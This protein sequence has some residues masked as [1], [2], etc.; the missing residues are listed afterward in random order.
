MNVHFYR[1]CKRLSKD[2]SVKYGDFGDV[3]VAG[4][5]MNQLPQIGVCGKGRGP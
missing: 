3:S 1:E 5:K 4:R 2:G